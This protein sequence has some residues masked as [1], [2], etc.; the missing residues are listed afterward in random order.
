MCSTFVRSLLLLF[1]TFFHTTLSVGDTNRGLIYSSAMA[2]ASDINGWVMEGDGEV[3]F[4]DGWLEMYSADQQSHH[5]FWCPETFPDSFIAEWEVQNLNPAAG[6]L[7][8]FFAAKG[9]NGRDIFDP[10]LALRDGTFSQYTKGDIDAYHLSYY[11]NTPAKPAREQ[12]HLRRNSGFSLVSE[13]PIGIPAD[14]IAAHNVRL[15]KNGPS[16]QFYVDD[17]LV[18]N[19]TDDNKL[20]PYLKAGKIGFRQMKWTHFRYRNF[21]VYPF[22]ADQQ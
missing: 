9:E 11:A 20:G 21:K 6:L 5:V 18:I 1:F 12:A 13:G 4:K 19:W 22:P 14:S 17:Q 8:V 7:I 15:I 3:V 2:N 16:I 10:S